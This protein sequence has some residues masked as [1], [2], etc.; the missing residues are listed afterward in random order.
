V[1]NLSGIPTSARRVA[2]RLHEQQAFELRKAGASYSKIGEKL[3]C[4]KGAAYK[5]VDRVLQDLRKKVT[6]D[7]EHV[8]RMEL[9]RLDDLTI[10]VYRQAKEGNVA[11]IDRVLKLMERRA[12][13][14]GLDEPDQHEFGGLGG[15]RPIN[16]VISSDD[17]KL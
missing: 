8:K 14:L 15:G 17:A 11:C 12:K 13:I 9:E 16:I 1:A 7:A 10:A 5:M 2:A 3:G 6:E 4:S